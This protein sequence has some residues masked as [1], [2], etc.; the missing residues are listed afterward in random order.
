MKYPTYPVLIEEVT[1]K[2]YDDAK[3]YL[4][5]FAEKELPVLFIG[6]EE[7]QEIYTI[8]NLNPGNNYTL[9]P[10]E[11]AIKNYSENEGMLDWL[12]E[13]GF[14]EAPYDIYPSG[15]VEV[16]V[17]RATPK[18]KGIIKKICKEWEGEAQDA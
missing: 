5:R 1:Y 2:D 11:F 8:C 3:L 14:V 15:W 12:M 7:S 13:N 18:L 10:F 4:T 16:P 17:C 6:D 9:L